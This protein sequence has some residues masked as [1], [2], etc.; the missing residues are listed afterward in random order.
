MG[1]TVV[2]MR[3]LLLIVNNSPARTS[4]TTHRAQH[5][6]KHNTLS[7]KQEKVVIKSKAFPVGLQQSVAQILSQAL[8]HLV[9]A[10]VGWSSCWAS[11]CPPMWPL[12]GAFKKKKGK[13]F[14]SFC[15]FSL[16]FSWCLLFAMQY[17]SK[18]CTY[19]KYATLMSLEISIQLWNHHHIVCHERIHAVY[20]FPLASFIYYCYFGDKNT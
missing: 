3:W 10:T 20:K 19:I 8:Q 2:N 15:R 12:F 5:K 13:G 18:H 4:P 7:K 6:H 16:A 17:C 9:S 11:P 14:R 1:Q